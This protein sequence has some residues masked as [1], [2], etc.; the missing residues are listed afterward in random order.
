MTVL[1][2][3]LSGERFFSEADIFSAFKN[4]V[5][6]KSNA[7]FTGRPATHLFVG[8]GCIV[9]LRTD[10]VFRDV[11]VLRKAQS[12]KDHEL[13]LSV[14]H[15]SKTWFYTTLNDELVV[16]SITQQLKP[17]HTLI[18]ALLPKDWR[19]VSAIFKAF[20]LLYFSTARD[21]DSRL[22]E[23]LSNFGLDENNRLFYV[24]DDVYKWD[25]FTSFINLYVVWIR[26]LNFPNPEFWGEVTD[27]LVSS[28]M[29]VYNSAHMVQVVYSQFRSL[30]AIN[31]LEKLCLETTL[32]HLS[33]GV[34]ASIHRITPNVA[35]VP[36]NDTTLSTNS[37]KESVSETSEAVPI[38]NVQVAKHY[39]GQT[40]PLSRLAVLDAPKF[41]ILADIHAN[42]SALEK[43]LAELKAKNINQILILGDL[44]GY[45][46][47]PNECLDILSQLDCVSIKGNHD[48]GA[49]TGDFSR[50]FSNLALWSIKWTHEAIDA[51]RRQW[52]NLLEPVFYQDSWMAVHGAPI[53]K[54]FFY[55]YVYQ[56]TYQ[57]NLDW[58]KE[59]N[60][61]F[62]FH[63]HSHIQANFADS[64][65]SGLGKVAGREQRLQDFQQALLCPGSVGQPRG[66]DVRAE[67]A[68]Y[69]QQHKIIEFCSTDYDIE[70]TVS[71]MRRLNFPSALYER[72]MQGK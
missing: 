39:D 6:L 3:S 13:K 41:A 45:G 1:L 43:V 37:Q 32:N 5:I 46:P 25:Q 2:E 63:G 33:A 27:H 51:T 9:K 61:D 38:T 31:E 35:S 52:L 36:S 68:I 72:L 16:G 20:F 12:A 44:V 42:A 62:A 21:F 18:P 50:G 60:L 66:G 55:A 54:Y 58:L 7:E 24:D 15:P 10:F 22:D 56:M 34:K 47:H 8:D 65:Q 30:T 57:A 11:D 59:R 53:D 26:Q 4:P 48:Y 40:S 17:L 69:D 29:T 71:D 67:Y 70:R 19:A 28:L 64:N 49:A 23:G 14:H